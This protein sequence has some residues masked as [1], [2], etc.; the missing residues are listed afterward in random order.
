MP[1]RTITAIQGAGDW[2]SSQ[3]K[4]FFKF[5][6]QFDDGS[7]GIANAVS[8][9]PWYKVGDKVDVEVTKQ[10]QGVDQIKVRKEDSPYSQGGNFAGNKM[11]ALSS[12]PD[13]EK[14]IRA[15]WALKTA[16]I[17]LN[18]HVDVGT[19]ANREWKI[20]NEILLIECAKSCLRAFHIVRD[21]PR[22]DV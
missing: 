20:E 14:S 2:T 3:G 22:I 11:P 6:I 5:E 10:F 4:Q 17:L 12:Q 13:R 9:E 18:G 15:H 19:K 7:V 8:A 16:A 21:D 1:T